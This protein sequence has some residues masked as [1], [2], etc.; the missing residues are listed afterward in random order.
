MYL[1]DGNLL[2]W[3]SSSHSVANSL[4][5]RF[6]DLPGV[7]LSRLTH[8]IEQERRGTGPRSRDPTRDTHDHLPSRDRSTHTTEFSQ[9]GANLPDAYNRLKV[10]IG[11]VPPA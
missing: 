1:N 9:A 5:S 10:T 6:E 3:R 2:A 4:T 8:N 11:W 7:S